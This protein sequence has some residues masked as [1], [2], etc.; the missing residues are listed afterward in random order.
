MVAVLAADL[1]IIG[2][3]PHEPSIKEASLWVVFYV[4]LALAFGVGI[5]LVSGHR[6]GAE[7][8]A[9]WITEYSL[10]VD[11]L[12]VFV[13]IMARFAGPRTYQQ[14]VLLNGI[15]LALIMRG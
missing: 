9:G 4:A 11:N 2:R 1:A 5:L 10:S 7:F 6:Y 12:C 3:R 8:F 15:I 13:V 14:K